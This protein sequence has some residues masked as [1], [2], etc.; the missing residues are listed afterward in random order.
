MASGDETLLV[1]M[2]VLSVF[3]YMERSI[4]V[5]QKLGDLGSVAVVMT[6][7]VNMTSWVNTV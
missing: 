2:L 5:S 7:E 3:G 6:S 1:R 4:L